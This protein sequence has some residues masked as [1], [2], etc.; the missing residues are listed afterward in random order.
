MTFRYISNNGDAIEFGVASPYFADPDALL[1]Y[2]FDFERSGTT[3]S[4]IVI[5]G[6]ERSLHITINADTEEEGADL[7]DKMARAFEYDVRLGVPGVIEIDGYTANAFVMAFEPFTDD[8]FGLY[9]VE[10]DASVVFIAAEWTRTTT[11]S[12]YKRSS[13]AQS[14]GVGY[15]HDYPHD[16]GCSVQHG[17]VSNPAPTPSDICITMYGPAVHPYVIIGGNRYEVDVTVE[18]G[19]LLIIDGATKTDRSIVLRSQTGVETNAFSFRRGVQKPGSGSFVFEQIN[20]GLSIV[21]WSG[22]FGFD[23]EMFER[24]A[25]RRCS[26]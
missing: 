3:I 9:S 1:G 2:E 26:P 11:H 23:V 24:R 8:S 12:F 22:T 10:I 21:E 4:G 5:G 17:I 6:A 15:P 20:P 13:S 25:M 16:Y 19:G 14:A 7:L 18:D